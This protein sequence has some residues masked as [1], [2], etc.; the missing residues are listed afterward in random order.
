MA[1]LVKLAGQDINLIAPPFGK[2]RQVISAIN[3]LQAISKDKSKQ[4]GIS[5]EAMERI[6]FILA[7]M[8]QK[9]VEEIDAMP[10]GILEMTE[11][12]THVPEVCGIVEVKPGEAT[13]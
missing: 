8:T 11:A 13:A 2:L 1:K 7:I 9:T 4:D 5:Q 3:E 12:M 10:I 6:G